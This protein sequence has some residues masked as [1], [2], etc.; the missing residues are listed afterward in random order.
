MGDFMEIFEAYGGDY[1]FTMG[2]FMNNEALY[3]K[4]LDMLFE[5]ENLGK[6]GTALEQQDYEA[7]FTAAHTLKG[8]S[9]N[10]GLTPLFDAVCVLVESIRYKKDPNGYAAQYQVIQTEFQRADELRSRLKEGR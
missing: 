3:L 1:R 5:D 8:V 2:R 6:L 9:G 10:M 4:F 7:A